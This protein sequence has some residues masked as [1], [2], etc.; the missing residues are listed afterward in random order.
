MEDKEQV[1][2]ARRPRVKSAITRALAAEICDGVF[3]AGQLLPRENDLG[4][5]YG[6]SRT[7][8]REALKVLESKGF[9]VGR[10]RIGTRVCA[11]GDWKILDP[12]V[13][14]WIGERIF[15]ADL[16][17]AI[18]EARRAIEPVAAE[19][20][21]ERASVQEIADLDA[22]WRR[23]RDGEG[24][25]LA[26]TEADVAFHAGLLK[27]SHNRIFSELSGVIEAALRF[28][29]KAS[30]AAVATHEEALDVHRRLVEALRLR[31]GA[32]AR[33]CSQTMLDLAERDLAGARHRPPQSG[34]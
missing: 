9:V 30:N 16:I 22:A 18:L 28:S 1:A 11:R 20:A 6:V 15:D 7:V 12:Q 13:L 24:D 8:I 27:A 29:L 14:D 25:L 21:A 23:M 3:A 4:Q 10:S 26:F 2:P 31:D 17:A 19:L 34:A 32:A 5:R 33:Q